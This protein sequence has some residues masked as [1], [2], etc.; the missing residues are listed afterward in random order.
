MVNIFKLFD[1]VVVNSVGC[2]E[3]GYIV[4]ILKVI[5]FSL[6]VG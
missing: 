2:L 1:K 6:I 5:C 3:V 4:W